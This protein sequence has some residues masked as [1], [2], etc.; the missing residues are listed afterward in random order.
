MASVFELQCEGTQTELLFWRILYA[1]HVIHYYDRLKHHM[2][3]LHQAC[4]VQSTSPSPSPYLPYSEIQ[5]ASKNCSIPFCLATMKLEC[6]VAEHISNCS[7][8]L[9]RFVLFVQYRSLHSAR[10]ARNIAQRIMR[11]I[12]WSPT[13]LLFVREKPFTGEPAA[14]QPRLYA[15][16]ASWQRTEA[17]QS[18]FQCGC[19]PQSLNGQHV[20]T[21]LAHVR[22]TLCRHTNKMKRNKT[23]REWTERYR[24]L[25]WMVLPLITGNKQ[26]G[27]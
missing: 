9:L 19:S 11:R 6:N 24:G 15:L 10:V 12:V 18:L 26:H 14:S 27:K 25:K 22:A 23:K 5:Y 4:L 7:H 17:S 3:F 13:S 16:A 1:L 8:I 2:P 20:W 21:T